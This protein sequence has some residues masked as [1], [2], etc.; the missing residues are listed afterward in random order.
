M[1]PLSSFGLLMVALLAWKS[2]NLWN[3][4]GIA[5]FQPHYIPSLPADTFKSFPWDAH[6]KL[7]NAEIKWQGEL[8]GPESLAFDS[9]GRG[10][11]AGVMDGR[12]VRYDGPHLGWTT[13][14]YTSKNRCS[15]AGYPVLWHFVSLTLWIC[16]NASNSSHMVLFLKNKIKIQEGQIL[17]SLDIIEHQWLYMVTSLHSE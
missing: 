16:R 1:T 4:V 7:R 15:A 10:P 12:I 3:H 9:Q 17:S 5:G 2:M 8:Q 11:Y 13:F 14:A 6:N